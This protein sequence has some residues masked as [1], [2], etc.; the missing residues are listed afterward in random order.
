M[1]NSGGNG[2]ESKPI[3]KSKHYAQVDSPLLGILNLVKLKITTNNG[4][5]IIIKAACIEEVDR[6]EREGLGIVNVQAPVG[7]G[8]DNVDNEK[9]ADEDVGDGEEGR[10]ERAEQEGRDDGPV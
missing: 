2:G 5:Y 1:R 9:I 3:G 8:H 7:Y 6:I 4:F 10:Y